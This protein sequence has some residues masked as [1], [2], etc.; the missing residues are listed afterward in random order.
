MARGT[1]TAIRRLSA[2]V[3]PAVLVLGLT[4]GCGLLGTAPRPDRPAATGQGALPAG[5]ERPAGRERTGNGAVVKGGSVGGEGSPCRLPVTFDHAEHWQP[6]AVAR[7]AEIGGPVIGTVT[8]ACEIN[9]QL[10]GSIGFLR[11]WTGD[12]PGE[13]PHRAL[14]SFVADNAVSRKDD[15]YTVTRAGEY[16]AVE[17]TY[18]NT[19]DLLEE[20]RTER[21]LAFATPGGVVIL[22][23]GGLD[24]AEHR[25][26]LPA[27]ALAKK[28]V[29][30]V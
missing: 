27:Y 6:Q 18:L 28:T 9:A 25:A 17:V 23:L 4:V 8:L 10:S 16:D 14:T 24:S 22:D 15:A 30:A 3:F 7:E 29:R 19:N 21:A 12:T 26:M 13:D 11:V 5:D 1:R 20:P 2:A